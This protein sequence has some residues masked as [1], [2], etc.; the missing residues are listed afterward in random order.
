MSVIKLFGKSLSLQQKSKKKK[1]NDRRQRSSLIQSAAERL[2][3]A[4]RTGQSDFQNKSPSQLRTKQITLGPVLN[5]SYESD[6]SRVNTIL[7]SEGLSIDGSLSTEEVK[8]LVDDVTG[9]AIIAFRGT[10][11]SQDLTPDLHIALDSRKHS[12]F[13]EAIDITKTVQEKYGEGNVIAMGHSL[14]GTLALHVNETLNVPAV[15]FNP[16]AS[17]LGDKHNYHSN[18]RIY[19]NKADI[20]TA[21]TDTTG[22]AEVIKLQPNFINY[23]I[24]PLYGALQSHKTTQFKDVTYDLG[25]IPE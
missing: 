7:K 2:Q 25:T 10:T 18:A 12:R 20:I 4:I 6:F 5:A 3:K 19:Q 24:S 14:G 9:K 13:Q 11:T 1:N 21:G 16:G 22:E 15:A 23:F 17:P 8:V